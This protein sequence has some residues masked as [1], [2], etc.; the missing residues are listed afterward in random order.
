MVHLSTSPLFPNTDNG[1][2]VMST[3]YANNIGTDN[4]LVFSGPA[5]L[6][7]P[8]CAGPAPCA[9]DQVTHLDHAVPL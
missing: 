2:R 5:T 8:G 1:E 4:T 3:T 9:F 6:S 7:S